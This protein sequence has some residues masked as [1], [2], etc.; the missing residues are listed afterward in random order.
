MTAGIGR[1]RAQW[2]LFVGVPSDL[3]GT[4]LTNVEVQ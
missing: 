3:E 2:P 1:S 4:D